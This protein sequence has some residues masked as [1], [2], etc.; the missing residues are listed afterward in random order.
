MDLHLEHRATE[1]EVH[2][3][4]RGAGQAPCVTVVLSANVFTAGL[5]ALALAWAVAPRVLVQTSR[6]EPV[7]AAALVAK[8]GAPELSLVPGRDVAVAPAGEIHVYG[9]GETIAALRKSVTEAGRRDLVVR[10]HGPGLGLA[11]I[12]NGNIDAADVAADVTPFD[13]R[14]C[15][16]PRIVLVEGDAGR[17]SA[18]ARALDHALREEASRI[19]P[20][21]AEESERTGRVRY[22]RAMTY[23]GELIDAGTHVI[24]VAPPGAPITVPPTG[25]VVHVASVA[26]AGEAACRIDPL[27]SHVTAVGVPT[28]RQVA[29]VP[30]APPHARILGLGRMQCPPLDGPVDRR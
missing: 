3:L 22:A 7:F 26:D 9:R 30:W 23:A 19:P 25:R 15:L 28:S 14:G 21:V 1:G 8:V 4:V 6:R 17:A 5:R 11:W 20:G 12:P 10:A 24:G 18:F 13:Q 27:R 29:S 2:Q 16:S